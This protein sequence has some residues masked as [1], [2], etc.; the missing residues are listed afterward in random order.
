MVYT[1]NRPKYLDQIKKI[2]VTAPNAPNRPKCPDSTK[3]SGSDHISRIQNNAGVYLNIQDLPGVVKA[4]L[5]GQAGV[6]RIAV[7]VAP[8]PDGLVLGDAVD[9]LL[10]PLAHRGVPHSQ[11]L[12]SEISFVHV[13]HIRW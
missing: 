8:D 1:R 11:N 6:G 10:T 2:I 3:I 5:E 12:N 4:P 7:H 9:L 13:N